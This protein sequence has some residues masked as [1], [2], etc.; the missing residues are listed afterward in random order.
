MLLLILH[1]GVLMEL[2]GPYLST[3]LSTFMNSN[4]QES[5]L[6]LTLKQESTLSSF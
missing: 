6:P 4:L 2:F 3:M 1:N 5:S